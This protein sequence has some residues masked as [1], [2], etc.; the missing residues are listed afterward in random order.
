MLWFQVHRR[1]FLG[2]VLITT[3][4]GGTLSATSLEIDAD[5]AKIDRAVENRN[6]AS[7]FNIATESKS[8]V[9]RIGAVEE[10]IALAP[11][12]EFLQGF[13]GLYDGNI[14]FSPKVRG[15]IIR[16]VISQATSD[17][18]LVGFLLDVLDKE[19]DVECQVDALRGLA[20]CMKGKAVPELSKKILENEN[21]EVRN[22]ALELVGVCT[23]TRRTENIISNCL[24]DCSVA[25]VQKAAELAG[26][27]KMSTLRA[28]LLEIA[29]CTV[30]ERAAFV[31]ARIAAMQ[32]LS[33]VASGDAT[34][35][36]LL[37]KCSRSNHRMLRDV[38][39]ELLKRP[40]SQSESDVLKGMLAGLTSHDEF[41]AKKSEGLLKELPVETLRALVELLRDDGDFA[42]LDKC[43]VAG[44]VK[45][46]YELLSLLTARIVEGRVRVSGDY[47]SSREFIYNHTLPT[48]DTLHQTYEK[49][50]AR[51]KTKLSM[52]TS[53]QTEAIFSFLAR[54]DEHFA[55]QRSLWQSNKPLVGSATLLKAFCLWDAGKRLESLRQF[56][57]INEAYFKESAV[58]VQRSMGSA[59]ADEFERF[60][61]SLSS[62]LGVYAS[63]M[64]A[65]LQLND[66]D[67]TNAIQ[68]LMNVVR[69][70]AEEGVVIDDKKFSGAT[71]VF[72]GHLNDSGVAGVPHLTDVEESMRIIVRAES[73]D[74]KVVLRLLELYKQLG[75]QADEEK[76][77]GY[78]RSVWPSTLKGL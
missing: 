71:R 12:G 55:K 58:T 59:R 13:R 62:C 46:E 60:R 70:S 3:L 67:K 57:A 11:S 31:E 22:A 30:S 47:S 37:Q 53:E 63:S 68:T 49:L 25:V 20:I 14:G 73:M 50:A 10:Y 6:L 7:L 43:A 76:L 40:P 16:N 39:L 18:K 29:S 36:A 78:V 77:K 23:V 1:Q 72:V 48:S 64:L 34:V 21:E 52:P 54:T 44:M 19:T 27:K 24:H 9:T 61:C 26:K 69:K 35:T 38:A 75:L 8:E 51:Q 15:A 4:A 2:A 65:E 17:M 74:I 45:G 28:D 5:A 56:A 32:A 41:I 42:L 33:N 66:G